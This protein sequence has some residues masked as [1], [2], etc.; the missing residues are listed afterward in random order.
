MLFP[1]CGVILREED[2]F[3][4]PRG[5]GEGTIRPVMAKLNNT[6]ATLTRVI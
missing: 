5:Y 6:Q 3:I 1:L 2:D 4:L